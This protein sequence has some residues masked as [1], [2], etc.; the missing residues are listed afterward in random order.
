M[1]YLS[2]LCR[3]CLVF[4]VFVLS[5]ASMSCL[6]R[7]CRVFGVYV[8]SLASFVVSLASLEK[9]FFCQ[10]KCFLYTQNVSHNFLFLVVVSGLFLSLVSCV[11]EKEKEII[12]FIS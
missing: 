3:L 9:V 6:W 7:L 4:V 5:L 2:C 10:K 11:G 12:S 1:L 8:V